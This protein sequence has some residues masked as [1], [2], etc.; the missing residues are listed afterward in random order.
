[1]SQSEDRSDLRLIEAGFPCHQVGAETQRERGA[2]SALPPL[3]YL[4]VWWARRPLTP[5]R[6]AILASLLPADT[7]TD[8][9]LRQL[10]IEQAVVYVNGVP[11]TLDPSDGVLWK[12]VVGFAPNRYLEVDKVVLGRFG[13]EQQFRS[14]NRD[15]MQRMATAQPNLRDHPT[16]LRWST[17]SCPLPEPFPA[18]GTH[19][20]LHEEPADPAWFSD[21][22]AVAKSVGTR[23]PNLYGY[24]RAYKQ[25]PTAASVPKTVLDP[26]AGGG[27]IPFEA[28]RLGHN[29]IANDLNPVAAVILHATLDYPARFGADLHSDISHWGRKLLAR[30][31]RDLDDV[32]AR[33]ND[34][35]GNE[36]LYLR[37]HLSTSP[38]LWEAFGREEVT[39]Y[40]YCRQ[41]VCPHCG[42][43]APLLNSCWLLK[44]GEQ[45]GVSAVPNL[46]SKDVRFETYRARK[47]IGQDGTVV[48]FKGDD[49]N[50]RDKYE[51]PRGEDPDFATVADGTGTC[52][53]CH[54]A[55]DGNE[56]KRQARGESPHGA[57][58]D[59]LYCVVAVRYQPNLD[60]QGRVQRYK[61]GKKKGE[62]RTQKITFFRPPNERDL[63][64]LAMA[65][66]RLNEKWDEWDAAGLIPTEQFPEGNDMRPVIYGMP[67]WCD[68][69]TPRQLLGHLT[70][71]QELNRIKPMITEKLGEERGRAVVTYLQFAVDKGL[72]YNSRQTL[73]DV[74]RNSLRHSFARHDFS[75]RW[76]YGEMVFTGP[77]SGAAWA[78][79]QALDAYRGLAGLAPARSDGRSPCQIICGT[80]S[81]LPSVEEGSVDLVCLDPPYYDNVQYAELSD[82]F[83]VWQKRTLADLYPGLFARRLTN[84]T[85]EA[86]ANPARDKSKRQAAEAYERMMGDI[87][88]ESHRV[89]R[90]D[91]L[92]AV[93]FNHKTQDA[94]QALLRSLVQSGWIITSTIPVE[95]ESAQSMH[96][97]GMAS[98]A[99]SIFI[100]CRKQPDS[101]GTPTAWTR[102]GGSGVQSEVVQA[103]TRALPEF[104]RLGLSP[105]DEMVA[106]YGRALRVLSENWPVLDGDEP[107][108][109]LRAMNEASRVVAERQIQR[110]TEDRLQVGDLGPEAAMAITLYGIYG[111]NE[112]PYDE[113]LNLSRSLNIGLDARSSGYT[114]DGRMIGINQ[115]VGGRRRTS[116]DAE[117]VGYHAPLVR[118]GSKLRLARP[119]ERHARR[120]EAPQTEWDVLQ[121]LILAHRRG[122]VPVARA[123]LTQHAEGRERL[124]LDL[125]HVWAEEM[126]DE[127]LRDEAQTML[128]GL[129]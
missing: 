43:E 14:Q 58:T 85:D 24:D 88:T 81:H 4:H 55:I 119:D 2:S 69:F 15:L 83:Y 121:G 27:S 1:M 116:R 29:V 103:V 82:F 49:G 108:S 12:R 61:S 100:S 11:W 122:D 31:D 99:S 117:S 64:A 104:E 48:R 60:S 54:Q 70:L 45:W 72:D 57:W 101:Q 97:K 79:S 105:V 109:P 53:H 28:L 6:A 7:D 56:I 94:W 35:P 62:I 22:M 9:F 66:Q 125:L 78:L 95:S 16:L 113:A 23:V 87:F 67:R 52:I 13:K 3:Y 65:Q 106:G 111:L 32:F 73:W 30:L 76:T 126:A 80:G 118:K 5:S 18:A 38:E 89:L 77:K 84:K 21:L 98:A 112:L 110:L 102:F 59:R 19:L 8:W 42:G 40:L 74:T 120:I 25:R 33:D 115:E 50:W 71:A 41:V 86:V 34:L 96:Q 10:G 129:R 51:G 26:T 114:V 124:I 123:Y 75:L 107:V 127:R 44:E 47:K 39:T 46:T 91:G 92:M 17:V 90:D 37:K 128:F 36:N 63:A 20:L 68:L 93:M